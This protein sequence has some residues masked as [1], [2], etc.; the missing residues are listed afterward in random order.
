MK[1]GMSARVHG[2]SLQ[3][4]GRHWVSSCL[5]PAVSSPRILELSG[6]RETRSKKERAELG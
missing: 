3:R 2:F 4:H 5:Q 1:A 6:E